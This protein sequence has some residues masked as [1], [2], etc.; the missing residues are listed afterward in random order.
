MF[1]LVFN[2]HTEPP[3]TNLPESDRLGTRFDGQNNHCPVCLMIILVMSIS[4]ELGW[5]LINLQSAEGKNSLVFFG[6]VFVQL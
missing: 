4:C 2:G 6:S 5:F 3:E 1:I